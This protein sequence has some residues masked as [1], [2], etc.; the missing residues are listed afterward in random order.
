MNA[1]YIMDSEKLWNDMNMNAI[2]GDFYEAFPDVQMDSEAIWDLLI[3]GKIATAIYELLNSVGNMLFLQIGEIKYLFVTMLILGI[4]AALFLHFAELFKNAQISGMSYY[5]LYLL[6][7]VVLL[8]SFAGCFEVAK[9]ILE[10]ITV[11]MRLFIPTYMVAVGTASGLASAGAYYPLLL[12]LLYVIEWLFLSILLPGVSAYLML[13]I[14]SGVWME[15]KLTYLLDFM[16]KMMGGIMKLILGVVTGISVLQSMI[17]PV[18][19]GL[20]TTAMKKAMSV[21]PGIGNL[22]EGMFEMV[23]GSAVLV[24]NAIGL[25]ITFSLILLCAVPLFKVFLYAGSMKL[26]AALIGLVSDK[27]MTAC[28]DRVGNANFMLLK[29]SLCGVGL[30]L[31]QIAIIAC[32]TSRVM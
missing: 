24:K 19:D 23:I 31:I 18:L 8:K 32:T 2:V 5:L 13:S 22:T 20:Q 4:T 26:G 14:V 3:R 27:R 6:W 9:A 21:I 12:A 15:E 11:F 7:M 17:S 1:D 30:F 10:N 29:L 16:E 25:Y 28:A